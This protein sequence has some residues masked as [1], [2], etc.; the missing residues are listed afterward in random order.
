MSS[1]PMR[2]G[3]RGQRV[4]LAATMVCGSAAAGVLGLGGVAHAATPDAFFSPAS[5]TDVE[6]AVVYS[7]GLLTAKAK[8]RQATL[9]G[10][11]S[12]C[13]VF[14]DTFSDTGTFSATLSGK[15][16]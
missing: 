3:R 7:P 16:S 13:S 2:I 6:A 5:C 10:V 14:Q 1:L 11:I 15:A 4:L 9:N 8:T 12:G